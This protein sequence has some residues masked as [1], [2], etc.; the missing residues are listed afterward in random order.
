MIVTYD[1]TG[2]LS[3]QDTYFNIKLVVFAKHV[4]VML[5]DMS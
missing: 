5:F 3:G 1:H 2:L 4:T